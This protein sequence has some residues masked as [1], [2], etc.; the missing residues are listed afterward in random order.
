MGHDGLSRR[1]M[2]MLTVSAV[3][4][5]D[6]FALLASESENEMM[7]LTLDTDGARVTI[8]CAI[9]PEIRAAAVTD[10]PP[11]L[12]PATLGLLAGDA[13]EYIVTE[14]G[15]QGQRGFFTRDDSAAVTGIDLA[16]RLFA[17][18]R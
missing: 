18:V 4:P 12:P 6:G 2:L 14:G 3:L 10:L 9:K 15:L 13:D 7:R 16:G 8:E 11:D 17:R 1:T 5:V